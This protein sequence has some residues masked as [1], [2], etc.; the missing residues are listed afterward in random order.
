[1]KLNEWAL[2]Q[3][4]RRG[5]LLQNSDIRQ[6]E[7]WVELLDLSCQLCS[8][9]DRLGGEETKPSSSALKDLDGQVKPLQTGGF[10]FLSKQRESWGK[11]RSCW[12]NPGQSRR[13][14]SE[15]CVSCAISRSKLLDVVSYEKCFVILKN[16]NK[17]CWLP[18]EPRTGLFY[19]DIRSFKIPHFD[20]GCVDN[21]G[22]RP[23]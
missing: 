22:M 6:V 20:H 15:W 7:A 16:M 12:E 9:S 2:M 5:K 17:F 18:E 8:P 14:V 23:R 1:M 21:T 13:E 10:P 4:V 19:Q 11:S 3:L